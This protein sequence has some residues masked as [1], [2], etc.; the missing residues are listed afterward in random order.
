MPTEY[1]EFTLQ[2]GWIRESLDSGMQVD[3]VKSCIVDTENLLA[4]IPFSALR[5]IACMLIN[6]KW[7]SI[8]YQFR[9]TD[10]IQKEKT[11]AH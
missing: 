6:P 9:E 10:P 5:I 4:F 7:K 3:E 2:I 1:R 11:Y 8:G